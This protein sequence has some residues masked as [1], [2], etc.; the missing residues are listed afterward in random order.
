M[1]SPAPRIFLSYSRAD[2]AYAAQ[3]KQRIEAEGL[4]LWQDISHMEAGKWWAQII[5]ILEKP[6]TEHMVLLVSRTALASEVVRREWR[7]ARQEAVTVHPVIVPGGLASDDFQR[8]PAWMHAEHFY[9]LDE[10]DQFARL[11]AALKAPSRQV[12]VPM[13]AP[14]KNPDFVLRKEE[15]AALLAPLLAGEN[16]AVGITAALRGAGGYGKTALAEWLCGEEAVQDAFYDGILWVALGEAPDMVAK[17]DNLIVLLTGKPSGLTELRPLNARLKEIIGDRHM[18]LVIDD[19]WRRQDAEALAFEAPNLTRLVTTRFDDTLA[20]DTH[21]V[22]VDAMQSAEAVELLTAGLAVPEAE[23]AASR[24]ALEKLAGRFGEWALLLRLAN[25]LL[26]QETDPQDGGAPLATA[27]DT[28]GRF[29]DEIGLKAFDALNEDNRNA[30]AALSIGASLSRLDAD[31]GEVDRFAELTIFAEDEDIPVAT[32]ARLWQTTGGLNETASSFLLTKIDRLAL[33]NRYDRRLGFVRLHDVMRKFL[34]EKVGGEGL[35]AHNKAW[36]AA[37]GRLEGSQLEG[38]EQLYYYRRLPMHLHDAGEI[39]RLRDLLLDP[40]W[41]QDKLAALGSPLP[42]IEDY[43]AYGEPKQWDDEPPLGRTAWLVGRTLELAAGPL[44][45]DERQL[46]PQLL[47]RLREEL[48]NDEIERGRV[49]KLIASARE[50][51][52]PPPALIPRWPRFTA[53]GGPELRRLEVHTEGLTAVAFSP[54]GRYVATGSVD[55]TLRIW[56][57]ETA[58]ELRRFEAHTAS[59]N[60]VAF[61]ADG[62]T[63]ASGSSDTTLRLWDA[64]SDEACKVFAGHSGRVLAVEFSPDGRTIISGSDDKILR[65]WE[66]A[67]GAEIRRFEGHGDSINSVAFSPDGRTIVSAS[68]DKTLRLWDV[69]TGT[70]LRRLHGHRE[71]VTAVAIAPNG[72]TIVSGSFDKTLR[73]WDAETGTELR[74]LRG[75]TGPV[76]AVDFAPDGRIIVSGSFDK[77]LRLWDVASG[78]ELNRLNGHDSWVVTVAFAPCGRTIVSGSKDNTLRLWSAAPGNDLRQLDGPNALINTIAFARNADIIVSSSLG[79]TL[80]LWD[81]EIGTELRTFNGHISPVNAVAFAPDDRTIVSGSGDSFTWREA[82]MQLWD[83]ETGSELCRLNNHDRAVFAIALAPDGRTI[84]SGSDDGT[85]RLWE[86]ATGTELRRFE[87]HGDR[88]NAVAF[89]PD[90]RTIISGSWDKTLRLWETATAAELRRFD[91]HSEWVNAVAVAP[92]GRTIVSGSDDGTLRLWETATGTELRRFEGHGGRVK[93]VNAVAFSP[94]GRTIISGS[95]DKTLRLWN[96]ELDSPF[97]GHERVR[98][99]GDGAFLCLAISPNGKRLTAG[100]SLSRVHLFDILLD[101]ADKAAWLA[102]FKSGNE[103]ALTDGRS[104]GSGPAASASASPS[105]S[106]PSTQGREA[107][108]AAQAGDATPTQPAAT[109]PAPVLPP[110]DQWYVAR[111]GERAGPLTTLELWQRKEA[112]NLLP[113]D[114]VWR[115]GLKTWVRADQLKWKGKSE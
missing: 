112:G 111:N 20:T 19:A 90:G 72:D 60:A 14:E 30:A 16:A 43:R 5:D 31:K 66:T 46:V 59:V 75:H 63:I 21:K 62:R 78:A 104:G 49:R 54:N 25:R 95:W 8:M 96:A 53:P 64:E 15:G 106:S 42:L 24:A 101:E 100:D 47:G 80:R 68:N 91:G 26:R 73:L 1:T 48:G 7:K 89:S 11:I 45:R 37:Y 77:T 79:S 81:A 67:T 6:A 61:A 87:G 114:L 86:T 83:V 12:R 97:L 50:C 34:R 93:A 13:M 44:A 74:T 113:T 51:A 9:N 17:I 110:A 10:P 56:A 4:V 33:F 65:L 109:G 58:T 32:I 57:V 22:R 71:F 82:T 115:P 92:H 94:D 107:S 40:R 84:V 103:A 39:D 38:A 41:M 55:Q 27:I 88:V 69:A 36:L 99:D 28:L 76:N 18:L 98:F 52:P 85:L 70:E 102:G 29:Y 35:K 23:I 2:A 108:A 3:Q 105:S